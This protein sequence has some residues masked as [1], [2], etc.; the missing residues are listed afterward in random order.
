[1]EILCIQEGPVEQFHQPIHPIAGA[2]CQGMIIP[3]AQLVSFVTHMQ[4]MSLHVG[5]WQDIGC[6]C[7]EASQALRKS[8]CNRSDSQNLTLAIQSPHSIPCRHGN[9]ACHTPRNVGTAL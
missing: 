4:G 6:P 1:M 8:A 3:L 9:T 2:M 5:L 7:S